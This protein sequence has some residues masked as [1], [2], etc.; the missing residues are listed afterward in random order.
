MS[1]C[2]RIFRR[3]G[4]VAKDKIRPKIGIWNLL[5]RS[6]M[7]R[8]CLLAF[9]TATV[10]LSLLFQVQKTAA[11]NHFVSGTA[12]VAGGVLLICGQPA[13]IDGDN[14]T[15]NDSSITVVSECTGAV[16]IVILASC[17][18]A[19]PVR[20]RSKL[21]GLALVAMAIYLINIV[22]IASMAAVVA[23][24]PQHFDLTHLYLWQ[25]MSIAFGASLWIGWMT[26]ITRQK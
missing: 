22:R 19:F 12:R 21:W 8:F 2:F 24:W 18:L 20:F 6:E 15:L 25:G 17:I 13:F 7:I 9:I 26:L 4:E 16:V 1:G 11:W 10:L 5:S 23:Y 14:V 3:V